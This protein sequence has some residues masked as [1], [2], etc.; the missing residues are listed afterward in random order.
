MSQE[1]SR[2]RSSNRRTISENQQLR[3]ENSRLKKLIQR[4]NAAINSMTYRGFIAEDEEPGLESHFL[5]TVAT[6]NPL[7]KDPCKQC[8]GKMGEVDLGVHK[9]MFCSGCSYREKKPG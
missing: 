5:D 6:L 7:V 1:K 2:R 8:G 4:L 9:Y 3:R